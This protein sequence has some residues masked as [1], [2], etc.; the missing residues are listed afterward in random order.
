MNTELEQRLEADLKTALLAGDRLRVSVL[1]GLKSALVNVKVATGT[2]E[3]GLSDQD[4]IKTL[5]K[6]AKKRQESAS[7][8][9][10]GG[11]PTRAATENAELAIITS[12]LPS[13]LTEI[14]IAKLVDQAIQATGANGPQDLGR[15]IGAVR[16][17]AAGQADGSIIARLAKEKL[18]Q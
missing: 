10:Q 17:Q 18:A 14:E 3:T 2:R 7:L 15:V 16:D 13:Q 11:D 12:Y 9:L 6:E 4:V 8:Y 5:A 1:R